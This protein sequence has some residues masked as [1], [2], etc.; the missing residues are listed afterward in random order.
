MAQL[1]EVCVEAAMQQYRVITET[2][3]VLPR[4]MAAVLAEHG[5]KVASVFC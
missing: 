3:S 4:R 1:H 5:A 2:V